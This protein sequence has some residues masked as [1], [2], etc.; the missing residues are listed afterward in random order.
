VEAAEELVEIEIEIDAAAEELLEAEEIDAAGGCLGGGG[1]EEW[2]RR[3]DRGR[4]RSPRLW[5]R[6]SRGR[7]GFVDEQRAKA[8]EISW[9]QRRSSG[10]AD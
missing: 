1:A 6:R 8:E 10:G 9:R 7:E 3:R 2:R 5:S 4:G